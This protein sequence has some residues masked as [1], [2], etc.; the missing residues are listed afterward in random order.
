MEQT[1]TPPPS[2]RALR[3]HH[4]THPRTRSTATKT[5]AVTNTVVGGELYAYNESTPTRHARAA[6]RRPHLELS[7]S[8]SRGRSRTRG[9][10][11]NVAAMHSA[12]LPSRVRPPLRLAM[13][14]CSS[15]PTSADHSPNDDELLFEM[16]PIQSH[17]PTA[18]V[19]GDI[20][21]ASTSTGA[22]AHHVL[23]VR[24]V[25]ERSMH[26]LASLWE[27]SQK[28]APSLE[29]KK[30][31]RPHL[32]QE[33]VSVPLTTLA[34]SATRSGLGMLGKHHRRGHSDFVAGKHGVSSKHDRPQA[35]AHQRQDYGIKTLLDLSPLLSLSAASPGEPVSPEEDEPFLYSFPTFHSSPLEKARQERAR[36]E[37]SRRMT[38]PNGPGTSTDSLEEYEDRNR[39]R[40]CYMRAGDE[41][42]AEKSE[43]PLVARGLRL[44]S[45]SDP[46]L[47]SERQLRYDD[48]EVNF[49]SH[50]FRSASLDTYGE[51][52]MTEDDEDEDDTDDAYFS[53]QPCSSSASSSVEDDVYSLE[54]TSRQET[55]QSGSMLAHFPGAPSRSRSQSRTDSQSGSRNRRDSSRGRERRP[56][57]ERRALDVIAE[58]DASVMAKRGRPSVARVRLA[59]SIEENAHALLGTAA[60]HG[61]RRVRGRTPAP[62]WR[63][64]RDQRISPAYLT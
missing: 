3:V 60:V 56:H 5:T 48:E 43:D 18:F 40:G 25:E 42:N 7:S 50:A 38:L 23:D 27:R 4:H 34:P 49:I 20:N 39:G 51:K 31:T 11:T 12:P 63:L 2:F 10:K 58:G 21:G 64:D 32:Q 28:S 44:D 54:R 37:G 47:A 16:S 33:S 22:N 15:L 59:A 8:P 53:S 19:F 55:G 61:E 1:L 6:D 41:D 29:H 26:T 52:D 46:L 57:K 30:I 62:Q 14:S 9:P 17:S 35:P 45:G 13:P 36:R 24:T